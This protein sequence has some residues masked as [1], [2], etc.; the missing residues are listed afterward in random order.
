MFWLPDSTIRRTAEAKP[1]SYFQPFQPFLPPTLAMAC[2]EHPVSQRCSSSSACFSC[3][4]NGNVGIFRDLMWSSFQ[5]VPLCV[6][7]VW[8]FPIL[9]QAILYRLPA[10]VCVLSPESLRL[11]YASRDPP[12]CVEVACTADQSG[13][14]CFW[15]IDK[16]TRP[17]QQ[18][19]PQ[20][21]MLHRYQQMLKKYNNIFTISL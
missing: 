6:D 21:R 11:A 13:Q 20:H 5:A 9:S 14:V 16:S 18:H 15:Q 12:G 19:I 4:G 10:Q 8:F 3:L 2:P 7:V 17:I 1:W